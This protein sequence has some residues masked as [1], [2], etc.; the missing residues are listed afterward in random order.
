MFEAAELGR[1]VSKKDFAAEEPGL[2]TALLEAQRQLRGTRIPVIVIVSGVEGAGKGEVVNLLNRW[3]DARGIQT[4][5]FWDEAEDER[6]RPRYWRFWQALPPRGTVGIMFGSWYT[7]PIIDHVFD[8]ID[9]AAFERELHRITEFENLLI[10]DGAL[11]V[12]FWFHLGRKVQQA[13]LKEERGGK[14]GLP[15]KKFARN[16]RHFVA[17][18]ERAIRVTDTGPAPW[19]IVEAED[20]RYR[21]LTVGRTLL[22]AMQTR[23]A[24]P[25]QV[26]SPEIAKP[27]PVP[28]EHL[29]TVLDQVDL[30]RRLAPRTYSAHLEKYQ[31][32]L[33][34]LAWKAR[35]AGRN[36]VAVF[37][38]WDAAGK[39]GAIRRLTAAMDAR[40][41]RVISVAAPTDEERAH[42]YLWRFWRHV[43]RAGYVTIYDRSW[44]GRVLVERV[45]R[46]AR[47]DE[48]LRAYQEINDFEEQ[49]VEHG[50]VLLKYWLHISAEEQLRRFQERERIEWKQHKITAE[51]WR[52]REKW[53]AY[54][55]AV[56]DMVART[57]TQHAPWSLIAGNDKRVARVDVVKTMCERLEAALDD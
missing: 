37:E 25:A 21:D 56:N 6:V 11:V 4:H 2:H 27:A 26:A 28:K 7:R 35:A 57:S 14:A 31:Q 17:A 47:D 34:K 33:Y 12:K 45:E 52:N 9:T 23:L 22:A 3:L 51:D 49:L 38:G 55:A 5:A 29:L 43:P 19:H 16:Y 42:H 1:K 30:Q 32:R 41:Y 50:V 44:Y 36:T 8:R 48:W 15:L 53:D 13:R 24:Q 20:R 46:F 10:E 40:L 39:G 54:E 18:S